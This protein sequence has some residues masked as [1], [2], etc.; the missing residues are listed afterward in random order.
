M[1]FFIE[2]LKIDKKIIKFNFN[3]FF[4]VKLSILSMT[5]F[6]IKVV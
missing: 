6:V 2:F 3:L 5:T 4:L 1:Y